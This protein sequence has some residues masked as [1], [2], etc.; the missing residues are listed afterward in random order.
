MGSA[1]LVEER[2]ITGLA[3]ILNKQPGQIQ[4][5]SRLIEDLEIDSL[6]T[7]DLIFKLE[8]EFDIEIPEGQLPFATVQDV[9]TY[10][11]EKTKGG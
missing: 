7:L 6:D 5:E 10:V 9:I 8:E 1:V 3:K 2:I 11:Q 4:K